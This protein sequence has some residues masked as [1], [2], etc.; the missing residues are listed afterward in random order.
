M[1]KRTILLIVVVLCA[2]FLLKT[3]TFRQYFQIFTD[4][5]IQEIKCIEY[6]NDTTGSI[7]NYKLSEDKTDIYLL[8][9]NGFGKVKITYMTASGEV[10]EISR[11]KCN[12]HSLPEL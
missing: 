7:L 5:V 3:Q 10:R 12:I 8:N 4:D 6:E 11:N 2:H 9:Y 1:M